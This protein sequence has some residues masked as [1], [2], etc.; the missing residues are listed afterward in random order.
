MWSQGRRPI[1]RAS[2]RQCDGVAAIDGVAI[3]CKKGNH[4]SVAGIGSI[5]IEWWSNQE[6]WAWRVG[7][8]PSGPRLVIVAEL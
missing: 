8:D 7:R 2:V 5:S 4:L 3:V 6:Q 1:T